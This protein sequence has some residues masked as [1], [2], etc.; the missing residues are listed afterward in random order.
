M[1]TKT[2]WLDKH[3]NR[4]GGEAKHIATNLIKAGSIQA[5]SSTAMNT[6]ELIERISELIRAGRDAFARAGSLFVLLV[7]SDPKAYEKIQER[8][9]DL[10]YRF[11]V[12]LE[13]VGRDQAHVGIFMIGNRLVA[14]R[15]ARLPFAEQ[16]KAIESPIPTLTK[17]NGDG[18]KLEYKLLKDA[19]PA[20]A[21]KAIKDKV[22]SGEE[23]I[24]SEKESIK[25]R[26]EKRSRRWKIEG[27][28]VRIFGPQVLG[29]AE[30]EKICAELKSNATA[31]LQQTINKKQI[32][33][34]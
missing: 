19:S 31:M 14:D 9:P 33:K 30:V 26:A 22:L 2:Q 3:L 16:K 4:I 13:Q 20:A 18:F 5:D 29:L 7:D 25:K 24:E 34:S 6:P 12:L 10:D 21:L 23:L 15:V 28:R 32:A 1:K 27:D 11:L 8:N 17:L